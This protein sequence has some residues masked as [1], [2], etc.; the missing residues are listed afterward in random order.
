MHDAFARER[1]HGRQHPL[2]GL[3]HRGVLRRT[4]LAD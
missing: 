4:R 2:D 1:L 3:H